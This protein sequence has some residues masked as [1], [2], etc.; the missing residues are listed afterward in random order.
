MMRDVARGLAYL[1]SPPEDE[2]KYAVTH[3]DLKAANILV[4]ENYLVK[5][6][7]MEGFYLHTF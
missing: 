5:V 1:H 3:S 2:R 4:D 7:D 6:C